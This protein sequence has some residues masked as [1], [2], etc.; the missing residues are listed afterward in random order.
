MSHDRLSGQLPLEL[1]PAA[2]PR[3]GKTAAERGW[4][5]GDFLERH[6]AGFAEHHHS[7][8]G[9]PW[10]DR[11]EIVC[12]ECGRGMTRLQGIDRYCSSCDLLATEDDLLHVEADEVEA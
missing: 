6:Q 10:Q 4:G 2:P 7:G 3:T 9:I 1:V 11:W 5:P 8:P 12:P